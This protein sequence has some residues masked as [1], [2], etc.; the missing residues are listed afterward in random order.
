MV[1]VLVAFAV[2]GLAALKSWWDGEP[3]IRGRAPAPHADLRGAPA[4]MAVD[5]VYVVDGDTFDARIHVR[6]D[7]TV[8]GRV[9]LRGVDTPELHGQ[10]EAERVKAEEARAV[11][12]RLLA[13]GE[14]AISAAGEEKYGRVLADVATRKTPNVAAALIAAGVAR[15]YGGGHRFGWCGRG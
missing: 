1:S 13:E 14:V 2:L 15:P 5:V 11:L 8:T 7:R 3:L 12:R 6:D 9:R 10:C 4:R